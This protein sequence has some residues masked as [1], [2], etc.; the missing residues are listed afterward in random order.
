[1]KP[2]Y[3]FTVEKGDE[4]LMPDGV[5]AIVTSWDIVCGG[6]CK[7]VR[8]RPLTGW[9]RRLWFFLTDK[10]TFADEEIDRLQFVRRTEGST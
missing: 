2:G 10:T 7:I 6:N 8:V 9:L 4:V 5:P 3:R 1:M